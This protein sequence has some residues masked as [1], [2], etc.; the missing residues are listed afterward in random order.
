MAISTI[1]NN[2]VNLGQLGNRNLIIN[3]AMQVAQR[4]TSATA[5]PWYAHTN[6]TDDYMEWDAEL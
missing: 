5:G 6:S 2:G 1:D 4:S 3:G